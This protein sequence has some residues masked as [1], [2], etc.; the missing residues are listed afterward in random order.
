[1]RFLSLLGGKREPPEIPGA[2]P[3][4]SQIVDPEFLVLEPIPAAPVPSSSITETAL[5]AP[6]KSLPVLEEVR[7]FVS[8]CA[9][10]RVS[11]QEVTESCIKLVS[12]QRTLLEEA[13][14]V[15]RVYLNARIDQVA[16][17]VIGGRT[18][19]QEARTALLNAENSLADLRTKRPKLEAAFETAA[20][21]IHGHEYAFRKARALEQ[22]AAHR[23]RQLTRVR[24]EIAL[25]HEQSAVE[26]EAK[27][28]N[29]QMLNNTRSEVS[30]L[31]GQVAKQA[32]TADEAARE[33]YA[34][35][36]SRN[37]ASFLL[38]ASYFALPAIG[39]GLAELLKPLFSSPAT[40]FIVQVRSSE[41][42]QSLHGF[43]GLLVLLGT[44]LVG[45]CVFLGILVGIVWVTRG[46]ILRFD[47]MWAKR[48][49]RGDRRAQTSGVEDRLAGWLN[50]FDLSG[51]SVT[52]RIG[53]LRHHDF[54][55]LLAIT[56][57]L[58]LG[59]CLIVGMVLATP[60]P[61]GQGAEATRSVLG[62]Y[63]GVAYC[64]LTV[65]ALLVFH[66]NVTV[67]MRRGM[68]VTVP[69]RLFF[70]TAAL[71]PFAALLTHS[72]AAL[73]A[74][75]SLGPISWGVLCAAMLGCLVALAYGT[76][77][78][79]IFSRQDH[80]ERAQRRILNELEELDHVPT[81]DD[82]VKWPKREKKFRP[83]PELTFLNESDRR[84]RW[85]L[86][87]LASEEDLTALN[88]AAA[89]AGALAG[90]IQEARNAR[91]E[92]LRQYESTA[93]ELKQDTALLGQLTE[94]RL[95]LE[96][97]FRVARSQLESY[98]EKVRLIILE[99]YAAASIVS[100]PGDTDEPA[101]QA[102]AGGKR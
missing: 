7:E 96:S 59:L 92:A 101:A 25:A 74:S 1:M 98:D 33:L 55:Q 16:P 70:G 86:A 77:Y 12:A 63:V 65:A 56:P 78:R 24:H 49:P 10:F 82:Y 4:E 41:F 89:E 75:N 72:I 87:G 66:A 99:V 42:V 71:A 85:K 97:T 40:G 50:I 39:I 29:E 13:C 44:V 60:Q 34:L 76:V 64:L 95:I 17:D 21:T 79:G 14:E 9:L 22:D 46:I 88:A 43:W 36:I 80:C 83:E 30:Q 27:I 26:R 2:T 52:R 23:E 5:A 18:R 38:W 69:A 73:R 81:V 19:Q 93:Q 67:P 57:F 20:C 53:A 8:R 102:A 45:I 48:R 51:G 68:T 35:G 91:G 84:D 94:R 15:H 47:P 58:F 100:S 3:A 32:E 28:E 61:S 54:V 90:S 37:V 62:V 6:L 31:R 11:R